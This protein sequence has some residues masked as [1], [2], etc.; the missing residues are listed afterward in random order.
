M[1]QVCNKLYAGKQNGVSRMGRSDAVAAPVTK[2]ICTTSGREYIY[3]TWDIPSNT[4][5]YIKVI[6]KLKSMLRFGFE[7]R[8]WWP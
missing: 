2:K 5:R 8:S 1:V 6:D 7:T 4:T 3:F